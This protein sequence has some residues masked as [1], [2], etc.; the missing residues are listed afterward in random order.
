MTFR[1]YFYRYNKATKKDLK[2][3][4][5]YNMINNCMDNETVYRTQKYKKELKNMVNDFFNKFIVYYTDDYDVMRRKEHK[6]QSMKDYDRHSYEII[7]IN[8]KDKKEKYFGWLGLPII[9]SENR[10]CLDLAYIFDCLSYYA[11]SSYDIGDLT[12]KQA[13]EQDQK[14]TK[15][16]NFLNVLEDKES[17]WIDVLGGSF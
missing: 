13:K 16:W 17:F 10:Y 3:F 1:Q 7:V 15:L 2:F 8:R 4:L 6:K 11:C 12:D 14:S 5:K 9:P